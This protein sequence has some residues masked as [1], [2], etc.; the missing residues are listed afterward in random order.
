MRDTFFIIFALPCMPFPLYRIQNNEINKTPYISDKKISNVSFFF[1]FCIFLSLIISSSVR[2]FSTTKHE[3]KEYIVHLCVFF[4]SFSPLDDAVSSV[5]S[6]YILFTI[7]YVCWRDA[8][9][10]CSFVCVLLVFVPMYHIFRD[11]F[12]VSVIS[13]TY[14]FTFDAISSTRGALSIRPIRSYCFHLVTI[15]LNI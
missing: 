15:Y 4:L 11:L 12:L 13:L 3:P 5:F 14:K 7:L 6:I 9:Q 1:W 2:N 10:S 8:R